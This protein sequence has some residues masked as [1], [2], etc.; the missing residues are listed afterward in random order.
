MTSQYGHDCLIL[1]KIAMR[2][3]VFILLS[4]LIYHP[5][6]LNAQDYHFE[7]FNINSGLSQNTVMCI[8]QDAK[9]FMWLDTHQFFTHQI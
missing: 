1:Q 2:K 7:H 3:L 8:H 9:G 4:V 5:L 6:T